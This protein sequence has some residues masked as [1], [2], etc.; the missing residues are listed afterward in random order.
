M[1]ASSSAADLFPSPFRAHWIPQCSSFYQSL[2]LLCA[3]FSQ[4]PELPVIM[5]QSMEQLLSRNSEKEEISSVLAWHSRSNVF[6]P[7]PTQPHFHLPSSHLWPQSPGGWAALMVMISGFRV[8]VHPV[9]SSWYV[10]SSPLIL[11]Y[12]RQSSGYRSSAYHSMK[13]SQIDQ[14]KNYFLPG[15]F[16]PSTTPVPKVV[17]LSFYNNC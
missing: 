16:L 2:I 10:L 8:L 4:L 3:S 13:A 17:S 11:F 9:P 7:S 5:G 1:P 14:D 6:D 15:R 12:S